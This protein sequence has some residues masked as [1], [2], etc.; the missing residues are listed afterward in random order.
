MQHLPLLFST[1]LRWLVVSLVVGP[2][3]LLFL[4]VRQAVL[5]CRVVVLGDNKELTT[6]QSLCRALLTCLPAALWLVEGVMNRQFLFLLLL[7]LL[8]LLHH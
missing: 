3:K 5:L 2:V 7:L 4:H 8:L 6:P 1:F